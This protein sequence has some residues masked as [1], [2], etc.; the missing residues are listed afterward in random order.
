MAIIVTG[1][2]GSEIGFALDLP[3][4]SVERPEVDARSEDVIMPS[5]E[6]EAGMARRP[7]PP[8]M[9]TSLDETSVELAQ[10][11]MV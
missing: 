1:V 2:V 9:G 10:S 11:L 3:L 6:F 7:H 5:L 4:R 8:W